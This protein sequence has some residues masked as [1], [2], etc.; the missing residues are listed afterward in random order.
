MSDSPPPHDRGSESALVVSRRTLRRILTATVA[1]LVVVGV[2]IGAYEAG[3]SSPSGTPAADRSSTTSEPP[4]TS[5]STT[6]T[7]G[8]PSSTSNPLASVQATVPL[9]ACPT[10]FGIPSPSTVPLKTSTTLTIPA[11]LVGHLS[12][13]ADTAGIFQLVGPRGW[14]C[15]ASY[16]ADGSGGMESFP[17]GEQP[18]Y[19]QAFS[20]QSAEGIVANETSA[21]LQ[22][23]LIQ[24]CPLFPAAATALASNY[25]ESCPNSPPAG[26]QQSQRGPSVVTFEDP[27]GVAGDGNP[28]GGPYPA[29][30]VMTYTPNSDNNTGT[31]QV[32]TCTLPLSD[33]ALCTVSLNEFVD[34]YAY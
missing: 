4:T 5:Q 14:K 26:E 20:A 32:E 10:S 17:S 25:Q 6:T 1:L 21:C 7:T 31:S 27:P 24:A 18:P 30:G 9:V 29:D 3:R 8:R 33:H 19:G 2:A 12:V 16:G 23:R 11:F 22:C 34:R 28:S 13:Y 15:S